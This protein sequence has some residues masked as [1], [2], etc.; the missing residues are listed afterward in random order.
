MRGLGGPG[1]R[2]PA[3]ANFLNEGDFTDCPASNRNQRRNIRCRSQNASPNAVR[4]APYETEVPTICCHNLPK[5]RS[6]HSRAQWRL[7]KK[8][9]D[10]AASY[11]DQE[12]R[13]R[14]SPLYGMV[15]DKPAEL[16]A[17]NRAEAAAKADE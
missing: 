11:V 2:L 7:R 12:G 8:A 14:E 6:A 4:N 1:G 5:P 9:S 13:Q 3:V 10:E 15:Q 17:G 16:I